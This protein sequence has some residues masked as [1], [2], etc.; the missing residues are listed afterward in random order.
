VSGLQREAVRLRGLRITR[1]KFRVDQPLDDVGI[2]VVQPAYD[3]EHEHVLAALGVFLAQADG[4]HRSHGYRGYGQR[5]DCIT[6][7]R[8]VLSRITLDARLLET[9]RR[10]R[11]FVDDHHAT[12]DQIGQV[13]LQRGWVHR[14][15]DI[16]PVAG[17]MDVAR[18]EVQLK[19]A[20][21]CNGP[22]RRPDLRREVGQGGDVV[23]RDGRVLGEQRARRLDAVPGVTGEPDDDAL[24]QFR[25]FR[26][27]FPARFRVT[28]DFPRPT[29]VS[30]AA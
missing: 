9:L 23:S 28:H 22:G 18:R 16:R 25:T 7:E 13:G 29:A 8:A 27:F 10:K 5:V 17:R 30:V 26:R 3:A 4:F 6:V 2:P 24:D 19:A 11:V 1:C 21:A 14:H 12:R 15:E 20:D